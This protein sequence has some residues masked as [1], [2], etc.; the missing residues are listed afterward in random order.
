MKS[1]PLKQLILVMCLIYIPDAAYAEIY[2]WTDEQGQVHYA[3][4]KPAD[5]E[6][7]LL[8]S[9]QYTPPHDPN[10]IARQQTRTEAELSYLE[11]RKLQR[12]EKSN[13][14]VLDQ[15]E[16]T[17]N[18]FECLDARKVYD[19]MTED[20]PVYMDDKGLYRNQW[21]DDVYQ[22]KRTYVPDSEREALTKKTKEQVNAVCEN[23]DDEAAQ[24]YAHWQQMIYEDCE[25]AQ[26]HLKTLEKPDSRESEERIARQRQQTQ[27]VCNQKR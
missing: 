12:Q 20:R 11:E 9:E 25:T 2:Q 3:D 15:Q 6:S 8:D 22:G 23:P 26:A 21:S 17:E 14:K 13:Q 5:Q 24:N 27:T 7:N 18:Y 4:Q 10:A 1:Y 19:V 16:E